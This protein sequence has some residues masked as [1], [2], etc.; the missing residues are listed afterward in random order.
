MGA[1]TGRILC[2]DTQRPARFAEVLLTAVPTGTD[3]E[4]RGRG[5]RGANARTDLDGIFVAPNVPVGD[6][7]ATASATGYISQQ[8][9]LM[10]ALR[11]GA[12]PQAALASL[13]VVHVSASTTATVNLTL[14]RGAV[15]SGKLLWDDGSAATGVQVSAVTQAAPTLT[16]GR[17]GGGAD[18]AGAFGFGGGGFG[19]ATDDRGQFRLMGLAP[20]V[21]VLRATVVAPVAGAAAG[22][23]ARNVG[24]TLYAPGKVRKTDAAAITLAAGEERGDVA[25]QVDLRSLHKV[26]GHVS[27]VS[28]GVSI[29][30]GTVRLTDSQD[31]S[32]TRTG[33]IASDG[34]YVLSYVPAGTYTL[35]VPNA[36]R[37]GANGGFGGRGRGQSG[38]TTPVV[39]YQPFTETLT[40]ADG[41]VAGVNVELTPAAAK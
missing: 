2:G 16:G 15:I 10:S 18:F 20:G 38:S 41:D 11:P 35:S 5:G 30:S 9:L 36:G 31:S 33:Q 6:Y 32:L 12:D 22:G 8:A 24:I 29:G 14:D 27:A 1:V 28:G 25:F 13:P 17:G 19:S 7:Y 23:F 40:V 21:Y 3:N 34:S 4:G 26:S 39:S 37:A